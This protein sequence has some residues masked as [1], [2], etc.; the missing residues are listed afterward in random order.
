MIYAIC[1]LVLAFVCYLSSFIAN[2]ESLK[3]RIAVG[4]VFGLLT[5][6]CVAQVIANFNGGNL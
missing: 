1:I 6:S 3:I 2:G 5:V 4:I